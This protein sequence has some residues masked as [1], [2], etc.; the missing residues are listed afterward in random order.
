MGTL[1]DKNKIEEEFMFDFFHHFSIIIHD[2]FI[3]INQ[4]QQFLKTDLR[5]LSL[6]VL[7]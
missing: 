4:I 3:V 5:S 7:R 6:L 1:F 2:L